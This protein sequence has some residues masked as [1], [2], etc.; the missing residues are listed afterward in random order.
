MVTAS[1]VGL[2]L[3]LAG[4]GEVVGGFV[5]GRLADTCGRSVSAGLG[6][7]LYAGGLAIT[8]WMKAVDYAPAGP[9]WQGVPAPFY[10]AALLFGLGD[11]SMNANVYATVSLLYG[12]PE[13]VALEEAAAA[14][15]L[16]D[17]EGASAPLFDRKAPA[18]APSMER[19]TEAAGAFTVFQFVQNVGSA[20]GFGY[21]L[22][23]PLHGAGSWV[24]MW[25]Q[26]VLW[27]VS[28]VSFV[29]LDWF[30]VRHVQAAAKK[31]TT[32]A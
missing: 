8:G 27:T 16:A 28:L 17:D 3:T 5:F 15:K 25:V 19:H 6:L 11:S 31:A 21:A 23:Y 10:A 20:V 32:S 22:A 26:G 7:L 4:V 14:A 29:A 9:S 24:Q 13:E 30:V 1:S 18:S 2:V 12:S